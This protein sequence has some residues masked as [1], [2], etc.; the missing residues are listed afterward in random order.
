M[1]WKTDEKNPPVP[2]VLR[3]VLEKDEFR[4]N[5]EN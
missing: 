1:S 2:L 4:E 3:E 5:P